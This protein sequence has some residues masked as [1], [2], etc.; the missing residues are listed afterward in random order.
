[1]M[2]SKL[3]RSSH[4]LRKQFS[5]TKESQRNKRNF[6][7]ERKFTIQMKQLKTS[8]RR[9]RKARSTKALFQKVWLNVRMK[10]RTKKKTSSKVDRTQKVISLT[11]QKETRKLGGTKTEP[12]R[13]RTPTR[14]SQDLA[15]PQ[16]SSWPGNQSKS[17][18]KS[19]TGTR[20]K[21]ELTAGCLKISLKTKLFLKR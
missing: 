4:K 10:I 15:R 20:C 11:W 18:L 8:K 6:W 9:K 3:S 14:K 17:R 21:E 12:C 19:L 13:R 5:L 2:Q 1:M 16:R 7:N